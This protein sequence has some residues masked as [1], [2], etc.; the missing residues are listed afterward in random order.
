MVFFVF[1]FLLFF[2]FRRVYVP[3][4]HSV[5]NVFCIICT[6]PQRSR[7]ES[8]S[9]NSPTNLYFYLRASCY[10]RRGVF[11]IHGVHDAVCIHLTTYY[12]RV[13]AS[14]RPS[15]DAC[16]ASVASD[17]IITFIYLSVALLYTHKKYYTCELTATSPVVV[18]WYSCY[19]V[20]EGRCSRVIH[21]VV[22][23]IRTTRVVEREEKRTSNPTV[24]GW[25]SRA[26]SRV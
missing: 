26:V 2:N 6:T 1:L 14:L 23:F 19:N 18:L 7:A 21:R 4:A 22:C 17:I 13:V 25:S 16:G 10:V 20:R 9:I 12:R 24:Y 8:E 15:S 3:R 5:P 11:F